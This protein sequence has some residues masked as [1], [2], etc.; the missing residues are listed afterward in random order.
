MV[1]CGWGEAVEYKPAARSARQPAASA[2][3]LPFICY[4]W[5]NRSSAARGGAGCCEATSL[6]AGAAAGAFSPVAAFPLPSLPLALLFSPFCPLLF[7]HV[8]WQLLSR[9]HRHFHELLWR[10]QCSTPMGPELQ[11]PCG[12]AGWGGTCSPMKDGE[13]DLAEDNVC[14]STCMFSTLG[15]GP[16]MADGMLPSRATFIPQP[17]RARSLFLMPPESR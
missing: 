5:L 8:F 4:S 2:A 1:A 17:S 16:A 7:D 12:G 11:E 13:D 14:W 9:L 6:G 10:C 3:V 15:I